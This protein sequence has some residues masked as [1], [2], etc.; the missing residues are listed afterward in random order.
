MRVP[1]DMLER[2]LIINFNASEFRKFLWS[3]VL[4]TSSRERNQSNDYSKGRGHNQFNIAIS[5][6]SSRLFISFYTV[7]FISV[8]E[9]LYLAD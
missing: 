3:S 8:Y 7:G 2:V 4:V 9:L 6:W 1:D 5:L